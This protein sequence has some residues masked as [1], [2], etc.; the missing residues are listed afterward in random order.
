MF[1]I[2][3]DFT[4]EELYK[5]NIHELRD[6]ARDIGVIS[7]TTKSKEDL[8][9]STLA[10]IYGEA[11]KKQTKAS[12]GRPA[13]R[14]EKP[15]KLMF[16]VEEAEAN[17]SLVNPFVKECFENPESLFGKQTQDSNEYYEFYN[18]YKASKVASSVTPYSNQGDITKHSSNVFEPNKEI[19]AEAKRIRE[20]LGRENAELNEGDEDDVDVKDLDY[21]SGYVFE[22]A[23]D[24]LYIASPEDD[25]SEQ[26]I[27]LIPSKLARLFAIQVGDYVDTWA[28]PMSDVIVS[29]SSVNGHIVY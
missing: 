19:V 6:L 3:I 26:T 24:K 15:S 14:R 17:S 4:E 23:E 12:A 20:L 29:I 11:P 22:G 16:K 9:A 2:D 5:L 1:N 8:I 10:I 18:P 7:P 28:D 25:R 21:V 27:Y 13:R